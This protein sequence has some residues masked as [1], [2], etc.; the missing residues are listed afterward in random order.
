MTDL[1][2]VFVVWKNIDG[3]V[4]YG[5]LFNAMISTSYDGVCEFRGNVCQFT[6]VDSQ[7]EDIPEDVIL[8]ILESE[9]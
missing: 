8:S 5:K 1:D 6:R 3:S 2:K 9:A 7:I 4:L